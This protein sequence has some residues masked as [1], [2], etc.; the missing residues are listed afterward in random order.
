MTDPATAR[1]PGPGWWIASDGKL[2][3]P[4]EHPDARD[5]NAMT[6]D[7]RDSPTLAAVEEEED[8]AFGDSLSWAFE[9]LRAN[10][11]QLALVTLLAGALLLLGVIL[12]VGMNALG[13][14]TGWA[15]LTLAASLLGTVL[16]VATT[17][18]VMLAMAGAWRRAAAHEVV[19]LDVFVPSG[20]S[21]F[22]VTFL[23][24]A[25]VQV[26]SGGLAA[27]FALIALLI[28]LR[29]STAPGAALGRMLGLTCG[30]ARRFF[31]TLLIGVLFAVFTF[32]LSFVVA[33]VLVQASSSVALSS[34]G[35]AFNDTD[36]SLRSAEE[37]LTLI[38][39]FVIA[40]AIAVTCGFAIWNLFGLW[41]AG[42][43]RRVDR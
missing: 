15:S 10:L 41:V 26:L 12:L 18:W 30:S 37:Q 16:Q 3:P 42:Y 2:Y 32:A 24:V 36:S 23:F 22:L 5:R 38:G 8:N 33:T 19:T 13:A 28:A 29:P 6:A 43:L 20:F 7:A 34:F 21:M 14:R 17:A 11:R 35:S 25:P 9:A 31:Q 4:E 27:A 40:G 39:G 1:T